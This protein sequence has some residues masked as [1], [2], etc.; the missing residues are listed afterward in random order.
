MNMSTANV[1]AAQAAELN[2]LDM[3]ALVGTV[4]AVKNDPTLGRFEF[5]A[6][7]RWINGGENRSTIRDFYGA[8]RED[9]SRSKAFVFTNGE[10]PV[11]LGAN[12][13]ANPVEFLL[14]A[15]AGCVTTT[16]VLH[17]AA[18]SI[19]ITKLATEL[20]GTLDLQGLL[21]L[22]DS[23][24]AGYEQ[25]RIKL[26]IEAD[27]SDEELTALLS[28]AQAHSPV[29]NTVCRPVPVIIERVS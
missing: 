9:D 2:G 7:N 14:H 29:C 10:P 28:F 23:V 5:R 20:T 18:R 3:T 1:M 12:E 16:I 19:R 24:P 17:A 21:G 26:D 22:D 25:I 6:R 15:L 8:G 13:G 11:L 4:A 27:C